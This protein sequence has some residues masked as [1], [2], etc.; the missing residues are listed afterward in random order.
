MAKEIQLTRSKIAVVDYMDWLS[1]KE[2]HWY[3]N[4]D[5]TNYY[6]CCKHGK[7]HRMIMGVTNPKIEADHIDGDT[8]NNQI[9]NLRL[10]THAE[11]VKS[12]HKHKN[13]YLGVYPYKCTNK[14]GVTYQYYRAEVTINFIKRYTKTFKTEKEAAIAY[15]EIIK[16]YG[17]D[18]SRLNTFD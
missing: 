8:L 14:K 2:Y 13:K 17:G 12:R 11:N 3:T 1:L 18:F 4:Y 10:C 6:A 5:G 9:D 16:L 7:M 15:N